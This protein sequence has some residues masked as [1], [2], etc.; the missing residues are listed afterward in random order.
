[1]RMSKASR[2]RKIIGLI[3]TVSLFVGLF[4]VGSLASGLSGGDVSKGTNV[5]VD[6]DTTMNVAEFLGKMNS[7]LV[8]IYGIKPENL[9]FPQT[10]ANGKYAARVYK[11]KGLSEGKWT[12]YGYIFAYGAPYGETA[13]INYG[14]ESVIVSRY[15][16]RAGYKPDDPGSD[17]TNIAFPYDTKVT[18]TFPDLLPN[19]KAN[20]PMIEYPWQNREAQQEIKSQL[21]QK[22]NRRADDIFYSQNPEAKQ[23]LI[24]QIKLGIQLV[25]PEL[26]GDPAKFNQIPWEKYV[27][28]YQPPTYTAWGM[29]CIWHK[30]ND[31]G[32][33]WYKTIPIAPYKLVESKYGIITLGFL[34]DDKVGTI[35]ILESVDSKNQ[36]R[37]LKTISEDVVVQ[38]SNFWEQFYRYMVSNY[39]KDPY[40][41]SDEEFDNAFDEFY[42]S[43]SEKDALATAYSDVYR[44]QSTPSNRPKERE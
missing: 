4:P 5:R 30:D 43:Y 38:L 28:I 8:E 21:G 20:S 31:D 27:H 39:G 24:E 42:N 6:P 37:L 22:L 14:G 32:D 44:Y 15:L 10:I 16:G 3:L 35:D 23:K 12:D 25:H 11:V 19:G 17:F 1:M 29:G 36:E 26:V 7:E 40:N 34:D 18:W 9:S 33:I 2:L 13:K 41:A